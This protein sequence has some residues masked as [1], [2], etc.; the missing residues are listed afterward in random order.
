MA[1]HF[2]PGWPVWAI[3]AVACLAGTS[4]SGYTGLAYAEFARLGGAQRTEATGLGSAAMFLGVLVMPSLGSVAITVTGSYLA[5]YGAIAVLATLAA[6]VLAWPLPE[7]R[8]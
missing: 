7:R 2:A 6:V 1:G 8:A 4:A 3:M 5:A